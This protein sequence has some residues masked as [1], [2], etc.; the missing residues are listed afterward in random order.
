MSVVVDEALRWARERGL[1]I[2]LPASAFTAGATNGRTA[3]MT[4]L[5][6]Q[7]PHTQPCNL[8]TLIRHRRRDALGPWTNEPDETWSSDDLGNG[9]RLYS[10]DAPFEHCHA[11]VEHVLDS[12]ALEVDGFDIQYSLGPHPRR[13][14]AYRGD[15]RLPEPSVSSPFAKYGAEIIEYWSFA[16]EPRKRWLEVLDSPPANFRPRLARLGFPLDLRPDRIGN[17]M[18]AGAEDAVSWDLVPHHD[19][20]LRLGADTD[21]L[22]PGAYSATVWASHGGDE[23]LRREI[24]VARE[25]TDFEIASDVD[26]I[27]FAI[28]RTV[29]GQCI[30][31]MEA[32]PIKEVKATLEVE[33]GPMLHLRNRQGRTIHQV[34]PSG[35]PLSISVDFDRTTELDRGIRRLWLERQVYQREVA[36]R[37][38]GNF[39]RFQPNEFDEAA[40]F[41]IGLLRKDYD[42]TTP[43]YFADPYFMNRLPGE[44]GER[45][46]LDLFAA[47]AGRRL[48]IL[49]GEAG[50]QAKGMAQPWWSTYPN[51]ITGHV[52]VRTFRLQGA[53][54]HGF[55]DRYLVTP[56]REFVITH[57]INGWPKD[58]VTFAALPYEIYRAEAKRLWK[59][60]IG[61]TVT[62]LLVREIW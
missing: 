57:S 4:V 52:S 11:L 34:R 2:D 61:S 38:E 48:R 22:V 41:F 51:Q 6:W 5:A 13:H 26:H 54:R 58:G 33:S 37:R 1:P 47:T 30:D 35:A 28:Y 12:G 3:R 17:L 31:L 36:A 50:S 21:G 8:F 45:L 55:H 44:K 14:R 20:T 7:T 39:A 19:G 16:A 56:K 24:S 27:G 53:N 15:R 60:D 18:I 9:L 23:V 43:V 10:L 40:R 25:Q 42:Q 59:M 62:D 49:S 29:D 46:Y 32:S